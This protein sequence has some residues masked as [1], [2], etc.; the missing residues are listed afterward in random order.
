MCQWCGPQGA[1][2]DVT[3]VERPAERLVGF[4]WEGP[5]SDAVSG[6]TLEV[7]RRAQ[8]LAAKASELW[9]GPLVALSSIDGPDRFRF[10]AGLDG[11]ADKQDAE[12]RDSAPAR[13]ATVWHDEG[14]V[15][16]R[17]ERLLDWT[18]AAGQRWDKSAIHHREEYPLHVDLSAP[19][20]MRLM[21]PLA[22][23]ARPARSSSPATQPR[24]G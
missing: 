14:D 21:L 16:D 5:Y 1:A 6:A 2:L 3:M 7:L 9:L 4:V 13:Y 20:V 19:P 23:R 10:F 18:R 12:V 17:Y 8:R 15:L 11:L 24:S 22:S